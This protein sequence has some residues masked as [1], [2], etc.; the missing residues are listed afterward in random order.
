LKIYTKTG[1]SGETGLYGGSRVGKQS[2][3][4]AAIGEV[5]ELNAL[6]GL[7]RID[8][9]DTILDDPIGRVQAW[10]FDLGGELASPAGGRLEHHG[11]GDK[12]IHWLEESIDGMSASLP[13]LRNFILP[14]GSTL[15]AHLH[16][17]R[18]V[19]RRAERAM[20]HLDAIEGLRAEIKAFINRLSDWLFIAARTANRLFSV[21]DVSWSRF[22]N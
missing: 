21:E 13:D 1:D 7:A 20:L 2:L 22:E 9:A 15:A 16:L 10:L 8:A 17:A 19:C 6:L 3:R 14:G 4:I 18:A 11:I 12:Q 5:D